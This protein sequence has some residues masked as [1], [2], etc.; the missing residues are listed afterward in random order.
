MALSHKLQLFSKNFV[1]LALT[2]LTTLAYIV[3]GVFLFILEIPIPHDI[4][5]AAYMGWPFLMGISVFKYW[6]KLP[7]RFS[8]Y[9][10]ICGICLALAGIWFA[11]L[12]M[13]NIIEVFLVI[14]FSSLSV[15]LLKLDKDQFAVL[16]SWPNLALAIFLI[17]WPVTQIILLTIPE[18]GIWPLIISSLTVTYFLSMLAH[19]LITRRN[20]RFA[21][22]RILA[23]APA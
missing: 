23:N 16:N 18:I 12:P 10:W 21:E 15:G 17:N 3:I 14:G 19:I 9:L 8:P 11:L 5:L 22:N 6:E 1:V 7:T 13:T 4:E 20:F 2:G